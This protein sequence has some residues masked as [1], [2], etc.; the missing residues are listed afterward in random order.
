MGQQTHTHPLTG[1]VCAGL[2]VLC[3]GCGWVGRR[4]LFLSSIRIYTYISAKI[5]GGDG[6]PHVILTPDS[7]YTQTASLIIII[8]TIIII[9]ILLIIIITIS[10][11]MIVKKNAE[12]CFPFYL[13]KM[14]SI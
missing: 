13:F 10:S 1:C 7:K 9:I 6:G 12:S 3:A 14:L 8:I 11:S 2:C 4:L 5:E